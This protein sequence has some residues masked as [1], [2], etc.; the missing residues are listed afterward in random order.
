MNY[1]SRPG[2]IRPVYVACST[3]PASGMA[4]AALVTGVLG[5]G[6]LALIFGIVGYREV[7]RGHRSGKGMAVT[8]IVLGVVECAF[9]TLLWI[10]TAAAVTRP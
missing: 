6:L 10:A 2:R 1:D 4:V 5:I 7:E 9:W 8:G 3:P